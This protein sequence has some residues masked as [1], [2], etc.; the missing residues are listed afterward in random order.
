MSFIPNLETNEE[1]GTS[2]ACSASAA[3]LA[4]AK[5]TFINL[6]RLSTESETVF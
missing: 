6:L 4:S 5:T 2:G 1:Q 3:I